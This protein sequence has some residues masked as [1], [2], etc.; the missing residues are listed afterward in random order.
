M[1][2]HARALLP[3]RHA[4]DLTA[5]GWSPTCRP[6]R[7]I[8][9]HPLL[10]EVQAMIRR[11]APTDATVLV[12]GESGTGKDV[13]ARLIHLASKRA[14]GPFVPVNCGAIPRD[15]LESEMFGHVR[16]SFTGA[17]A[18][19][20][21]LFQQANHGTIFLDEIPE[22]APALQVKLLRVL[23]EHEVFAVGSQRSVK[24]DIRVIAATNVDLAREIAAGRFREDLF[25]RLNV[26]PL[27]LPPLRACR[28]DI[29]QLVETFLQIDNARHREVAA[30]ITDEA[31]ARLHEYDWPGNVR[32]LENVVERLVI[33]SETG[34]IGS[35]D[36]PPHILTK[37][38][39]R[40]VEPH[41][42]E[43]GVDLFAVVE[44][45]ENRL[46]DEALCRAGGDQLAAARLLGVNRSILLAKLAR[47][48]GGRAPVVNAPR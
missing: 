46:I 27:A 26:I 12:T 34:V 10:E 16:G 9:S 13:A 11:V 21:G 39:P 41:V 47:R 44:S 15:L 5:N 8:G 42:G 29:P 18:D 6:A 20:P 32:E 24:L 40:D 28:S 22:M 35:D 25:Y 17:I 30:R 45:F 3:V 4:G 7:L 14:A 33:L 1:S 48:P 19:R 38:E 23:Q 2:S 36:L 37:A 31:M 43:R